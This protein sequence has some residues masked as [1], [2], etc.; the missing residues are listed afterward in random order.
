MIPN[1]KPTVMAIGVVGLNHRTSLF[2][3]Y[4]ATTAREAIATVRLVRCD[5]M[6]VGMDNP[7]IDVWS[8]M[9]DLTRAWTRQRWLLVAGHVTPEDE[10]QARSLGALVILDS[11]PSEHWILDFAASLLRRDLTKTVR[12]RDS[13]NA[14]ALALQPVGM[15]TAL[16]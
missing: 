7:K 10:I 4:T 14:P 15:Q 1:I 9:R 13:V 3:L 12:T 5:L 6:L 16:P 11:L 2:D 8:L